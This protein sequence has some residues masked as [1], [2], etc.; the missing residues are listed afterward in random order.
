M[1]YP[2]SGQR[3]IWSVRF[4]LVRKVLTIREDMSDLW[5]Q[6]SRRISEPVKAMISPV[7]LRLY[8]KYL[9]DLFASP[10]ECMA[11]EDQT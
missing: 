9:P 6:D 4:Y 5:H 8:M 10:G 3:T 7:I 11:Y 1:P 2:I